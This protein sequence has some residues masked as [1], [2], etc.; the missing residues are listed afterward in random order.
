MV[1]SLQISTYKCLQVSMYPCYLYAIHSHVD[2][3]V[4]SSIHWI[5]EDEHL[6]LHFCNIDLFFNGKDT[7]APF[8]MTIS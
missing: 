4:K 3:V 8:L 2:M 1:A 7:E 6:S 5:T